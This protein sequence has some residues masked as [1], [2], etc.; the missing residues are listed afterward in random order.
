MMRGALHPDDGRFANLAGHS[1][2]WPADGTVLV[3]FGPETGL[4]GDSGWMS[5]W[6]ML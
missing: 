5:G 6:K 3:Q 1:P 4:E 2:G